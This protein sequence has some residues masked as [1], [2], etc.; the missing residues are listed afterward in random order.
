[1][2]GSGAQQLD[3]NG[4]PIERQ[5]PPASKFKENDYLE[6]AAAQPPQDP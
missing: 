2:V 1:M 5:P 4:N 3:E 6:K